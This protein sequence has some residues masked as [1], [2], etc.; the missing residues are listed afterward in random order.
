MNRQLILIRHTK[1]SHDN[2]LLSDFERPI[3]KDRAADAENIAK[4]L[5]K[6]N[7]QPDLVI[8]SPA[9]RTKQTAEIVCPI[10]G[11]ATSQIEWNESIYESSEEDLLFAIQSTDAT[12]KTLIIIG[13]NPAMTYLA[14][15]FSKND[16]I[17]NV[18]TSGVVGFSFQSKDWQIATTTPHERLFFFGPK[19]I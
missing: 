5:A 9:K 13:H 14:N 16:F 1:S 10:L 12:I 19:T 8:C 15:R 18:P 3:R 2:L 4:H 6:F 11:Y 7:I 17:A